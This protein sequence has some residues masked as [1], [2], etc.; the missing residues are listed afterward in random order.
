MEPWGWL[1]RIM[2][3]ECEDFCSLASEGDLTLS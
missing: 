1:G 2:Q 3:Y